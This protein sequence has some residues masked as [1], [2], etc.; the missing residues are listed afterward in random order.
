[1]PPGGGDARPPFLDVETVYPSLRR[2]EASFA[3]IRAEALALMD[4][5]DAI[6]AYDELDPAQHCAASV[7]PGLW[8]V[9]YLRAMGRRAE[10]NSTRCPRTTAALDAVPG[11]F[12]AQ[13]SI[14]DPGKTVPVHCGPYGGYLRYHL[15][16]VVPEVDPPRLRVADEVRAWSTGEGLLFDDR[17]EHEVL[18]TSTEHRVVLIVDVLR[19]MPLPQHLVNLALFPVI[20]RFY[21]RPV[22]ER[23]RRYAERP[24]PADRAA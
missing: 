21:G 6:P 19:P 8:R 15:A 20:R 10:P 11:L 3:D 13:F 5:I 24:S 1:V 7:T 16:L 9:Y 23:A 14:L 12:Q 17:M 4:G 2:L 22:I 18:N